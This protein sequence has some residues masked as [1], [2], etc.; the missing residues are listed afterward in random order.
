MQHHNKQYENI[1]SV[2]RK[3]TNTTIKPE[4]VGVDGMDIKE[5]TDTFKIFLEDFYE[6]LFL[7][8]VK[9][10]WLRRKFKYAGMKFNV[11]VYAS[12]RS[13]NGMFVKFLRR[14]I[15]HDIQ[16]LTKGYLFS[17]L[18]SYYFDQLFPGF[19]D[20]NPF[21]N[22]DYYKF[23]YDNISLEYLTLVYQLDDRFEL[24]E[25]ADKQKMSYAVFLDYVMNHTLCEN[26]IL[27]RDRYSFFQGNNRAQ[28]Y[29]FRDSDKHFRP[30][31]GEKRI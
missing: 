16:I 24:L 30:L 14:N 1:F 2:D 27:K 12:P 26:E 10:S 3:G 6:D 11:P 21:E 4:K 8:L 20:G 17:K 25:E 7:K 23:P 15:G 9:L 28:P 31:K 29:F 19:M 18:E 5:Y 13:L 22:P